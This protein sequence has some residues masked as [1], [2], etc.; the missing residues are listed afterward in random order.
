MLDPKKLLKERDGYVEW[1]TRFLDSHRA[2]TID[3][4]RVCFDLNLQHRRSIDG[5]I[6]IALMKKVKSLELDF[7]P[8]RSN[9]GRDSG[10]Y[11]FGCKFFSLSG[12]RLLTGLCLKHVDVRGQILESFLSNC[13][14]LETLHVSHSKQLTHINVCGSSLRLKHL[15]I[16]FCKCIKSIEVYAPNLVSFAYRGLECVHIDLKYVPQLCDVSYAG[17]WKSRWVF[18]LR[19][20]IHRCLATSQLVNLLLR[21]P[22]LPFVDISPI[23][24]DF[25]NL[26]YLTLELPNVR[27]SFRETVEFAKLCHLMKHMPLLHKFKLELE[28]VE[29]HIPIEEK[30]IKSIIKMGREVRV[31]PLNKKLMMLREVEIVGFVG[32]V[33]D[34]ILIC[35]LSLVAPNLN[36][37]VIN[38]CPPHWHRGAPIDDR[39]MKELEEGKS[40]VCDIMS[41][42]RPEGS[43]YVLL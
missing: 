15:H 30:Y 10:N 9:H 23:Q 18:E 26:R 20:S 33:A 39:K 35:F 36:K 24:P 3:E 12:I 14:L 41:A 4:L 13:P 31:T 16:S 2:G 19:K 40:L 1:I 32:A 17:Q 22:F 38:C 11:R 8:C 6:K 34:S 25:P 43:K 5:W 42:I 28:A 27:L 37:I 7:E 21:V 29:P